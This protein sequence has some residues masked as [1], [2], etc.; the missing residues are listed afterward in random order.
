MRDVVV[1]FTKYSVTFTVSCSDI[2]WSHT[3]ISCSFFECT[4]SFTSV[5]SAMIS[6]EKFRCIFCVSLFCYEILGFFVHYFCEWYGFYVLKTGDP[7][8][9]L[10]SAKVIVPGTC[11]CSSELNWTVVPSFTWSWSGMV[12]AYWC[13]VASAIVPLLIVTICNFIYL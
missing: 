8:S 10:A 6:A 7:S 5:T 9:A 2:V 11:G 3:V 1:I 4:Y 12:A 13:W